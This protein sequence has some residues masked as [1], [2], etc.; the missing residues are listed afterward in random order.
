MVNCGNNL[1]T[2]VV[3]TSINL[4]L[5]NAITGTHECKADAKGRLLLPSA[6]KKQLP[7]LQSGFVLKRSI[8]NPCLEL[9]PMA[10]WNV[11]MQ[12]LNKLNRFVRE[13]DKFITRFMAGVKMIDIDEIGR[14]LMP[15]DLIS[16]AKIQK[17]VVFTSK[18]N[19]IEIWDKDIYE[20]EVA[21]DDDDFAQQTENVMKNFNT[22]NDG[23]S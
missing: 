13:N 17:D 23:L 14:I 2:F 11:M 8:Y 12:N 5:L 4:K 18:I 10:E 19:I 3:I 9:W 20:K 21:F 15:K 6:F 16:F 1:F 22:A 7:D